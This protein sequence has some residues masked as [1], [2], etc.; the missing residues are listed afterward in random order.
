MDFN[1]IFI[2]LHYDFIII[3]LRLHFYYMTFGLHL[4]YTMIAMMKSKCNQNAIKPQCKILLHLS[5]SLIA[6]QLHV[7][8]I[9]LLHFDCVIVALHY[10]FIIITLRLHFYYI[11]VGLC[12]D[13]S[14]IA[15]MQLKCNQ[16][17]ILIIVAV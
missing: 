9:K 8:C 15:M 14:T 6:F 3:T 11:T 17:A 4:D 10:D 7:D 16:N 1:I 2:A 13:Y 12:F 5:C